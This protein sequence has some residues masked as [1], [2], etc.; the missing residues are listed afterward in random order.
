[1]I[2][3]PTFMEIKIEELLDIVKNRKPGECGII[4]YKGVPVR[5]LLTDDTIK[6]S[7]HKLK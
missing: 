4:T 2:H 6:L 1:M 7:W 3:S 5:W